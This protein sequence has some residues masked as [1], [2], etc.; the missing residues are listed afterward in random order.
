[1]AHA[2]LTSALA[3]HPVGVILFMLTVAALPVSVAGVVRGWSLE[4]IY[5]RVH[6]GRI[7]LALAVMALLV[8]VVR[9]G[10]LMLS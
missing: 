4:E 9:I 6:G 2:E 1:M 8:W 5:N 7:V 3:A 10:G